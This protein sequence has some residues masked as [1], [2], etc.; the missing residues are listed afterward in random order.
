VN[1]TL[2]NDLELFD[3]SFLDVI[4]EAFQSHFAGAGQLL[5]PGLQKAVLG[6]ELGLLFIIQHEEVVAGIRNA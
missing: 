2:D 4:K 3:L 5:L 1:V 6:N